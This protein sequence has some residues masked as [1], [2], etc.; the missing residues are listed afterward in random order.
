MYFDGHQFEAF[1]VPLD[2]R[3]LLSI[4][5]LLEIPHVQL[6]TTSRVLYYSAVVQ[7][8]FIDPDPVPNKCV[9]VRDIYHIV[10]ELGESWVESV[11]MTVPDLYASFFVVSSP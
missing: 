10:A 3:F 4:P 8:I 9:L 2:R 5:D 7:G 1:R 6:D 11:Q